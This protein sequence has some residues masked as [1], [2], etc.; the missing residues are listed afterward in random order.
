M[1]KQRLHIINRDNHIIVY[2]VKTMDLFIGDGL[3]NEELQHLSIQTFKHTSDSSCVIKSKDDKRVMHRITIC[4]SNDCNLRCKYCYAHGGNY[5]KQRVLM[6]KKTAKDIVDFCV[7][8]FSQIDCVMFF[9]GEPLL[10]Y[11]I[12]EYICELFNEAATTNFFK[13]PFFSIVT[14]GTLYN[15]GILNL[16]KSHIS[17]I[18]VSIDG[19]QL[20]NDKNRVFKNGCGTYK[21][22]AQFINQCK[23]CSSVKLEYEATYTTD[24]IKMGIT[25]SDVQASLYS[26]FG[27]NGVVVDEE[28]LQ[29]EA[30][31]K[32]LKEVTDDEI[33]QT[34]FN[35]LPSDFWQVA[36]SMIYKTSNKFCG[37]FN[38]RI[39]LTT[40]GGIWGCQML[41]NNDNNVIS[42]IYNINAISDINCHVKDFKDNHICKSCWCSN[43]CGGCVVQKFYSKDNTHL[44]NEPN[45]DVCQL[46][47]L[48]IEEILY[49]LYRLK[50]DRKLWVLFAQK[51]KSKFN[52]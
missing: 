33:R 1:E 20:I 7:N 16:I 23:E 41:I 31:Y 27:I 26:T 38:D 37:I 22:I 34:D 6:N 44:N 2:D 29:K 9:G 35:C 21:R 11:K 14:N 17:H 39:T 13:V 36:L 8:N 19:N 25:R 18:T 32:S 10:N 3:S 24:H 4:V 15:D 46:T 5:G 47:Q 45:V 42:S 49:I 28:K 52:L 48:C 12:I 40:D 30:I 50:I 43:I 51:L